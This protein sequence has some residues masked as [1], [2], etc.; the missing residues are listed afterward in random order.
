M[1]DITIVRRMMILIII[2]TSTIQLS[3]LKKY[4]SHAYWYTWAMTGNSL[5]GFARQLN[6]KPT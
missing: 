2:I 4:Q 6:I 5:Q 1:F 3:F